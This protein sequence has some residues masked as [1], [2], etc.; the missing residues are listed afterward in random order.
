MTHIISIRDL[1]REEIDFLLSEAGRIQE[2]CFD[3]HALNGKILALL[4]FEP[5]TRT[6]MSFEA[7]M[8]RLGGTSLSVG[9]VEASSMA[10]G[11]TLADTIRVVSGYADAIVLRHPKE[12]AARLASEFAS[13]PVI[14]AGDGAG[15]HPSQTLLDLYT[16]RQSMPLER[17]RI[18]LL[19]DLRYGRTAHSLAYAL[20]LYHATIFS[21]TPTGLELPDALVREL[22]AHGTEVICCDNVEDV[23][24]DLDVL[25][26]TRIQRER[27]PD[28]ASYF[29]VASSYRIT[30]ELLTGVKDHLIVLHPLP[31]VD[32]IDPRVDSLPYARYFEQSWNGIP[33]R[34]AML[35]RV[36][37]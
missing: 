36:M 21:I 14:N 27:F 17:I 37:K 34:M 29:K 15:Q 3:E 16:I 19:G 11:E 12:G 23:V 10:K 7:A 22:A 8:A 13:V 26:V 24:R 30:P 33:V 31:R 5:S 20:S 18:G 9:S 32:E 6:R 28:S 2:R 4:F 1:K 35:Q 25:Y